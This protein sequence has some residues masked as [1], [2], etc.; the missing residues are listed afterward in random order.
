MLERLQKILARAGVAS[1]RKAEAM[2]TSGRVQV[3]GKLVT[4]LGS[5]ADLATDAIRVDGK[6]L[7][8][9]EIV[10]YLLY[11]PINVVTTADDPLQRKKVLD[12]VPKE[13]RVFPVGRLDRS[14]E[15]LILLTNDGELALRLTHP[16]YE[17]AKEYRVTGVTRRPVPELMSALEKGVQ[18]DGELVRPD[19]VSFEGVREHK[20][21]L[22]IRVHE[23][24]HHLIK[25]L[26]ARVS[27]EITHLARVRLGSL[28]LQG[29]RPGQYRRLSAT[30]IARLQAETKSPKAASPAGRASRSSGQ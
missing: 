8:T 30:E 18:L 26:C 19:S 9:P 13:P 7:A 15:G 1:R 16:R 12:F 28:T 21:T 2:I 10:V 24:R 6:P 17:H 20:L 25:R 11:K 27:F 23:G 4:N 5:K 14:T 29:L 22:T 3:N